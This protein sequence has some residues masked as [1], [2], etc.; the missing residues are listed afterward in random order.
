MVAKVDG[1]GSHLIL[2][3]HV[4][5]HIEILTSEVLARGPT[6]LSSSMSSIIVS[7]R[8]LEFCVCLDLASMHT[9]ISRSLD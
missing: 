2:K 5:T 9:K 6:W 4:E 7:P 1:F 3:P 8:S